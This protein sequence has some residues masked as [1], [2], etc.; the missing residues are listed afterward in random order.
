[1]E[2]VEPQPQEL[3]RPRLDDPKEFDII[4]SVYLFD[5]TPLNEEIDLDEHLERSLARRK[6]NI[7][8]SR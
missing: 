7:N 4:R 2:Q 6:I 1:M 5:R 3:K 8:P